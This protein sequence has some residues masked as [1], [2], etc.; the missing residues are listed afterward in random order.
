MTR[1]YRG[2]MPVTEGRAPDQYSKLIGYTLKY[3]YL[4]GIS[5]ESGNLG[6]GILISARFVLTCSHVLHDSTSAEV[7]SQAG[8]TGARVQ[9]VDDSL[10]LALLELTQPISAP[11][12]KFT[13]SPLQPDAVLL[14]VGIQETPG[15]PNEL[16]VAEIQLKYRNKNDADGKILDIQL[17]G[18][19]RPGYSGGPL[20]AEEGGA[21]H[22]VGI[23]R[24]GGPGASSSNAIGLA[25]IRAFL[26]DY[27]PD[28]PE[29]KLGI[30]A[31]GIRR[32]LVL[33]AILLGVFAVGATVKW[34][35]LASHSRQVTSLTANTGTPEP[36]NS[37]AAP[38]KSPSA[39]TPA[40]SKGAKYVIPPQNLTGLHGVDQGSPDVRV[41]V[42]T[43]SKVYHCPGTRSYGK[44]MHGTYMT[45]AE[46]QKKAN[47]P[48]YGRVC[49]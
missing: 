33:T 21:L 4:V 9:K 10:D 23:M 41:W 7:I 46:A 45:Q 49:K 19:A 27:V 44:T 18:G 34:L 24:F 12:P 2:N 30:K 1:K 28:M 25:S 11:K 31:A 16:S 43:V 6:T 48:A 8:S 13:D 42:N 3:P 26:A 20:I 5:T 29:N 14:A 17:E 22:C 15:Q 39:Q 38:A 35:Y 32:L 37:G 47:R 40:E 36:E